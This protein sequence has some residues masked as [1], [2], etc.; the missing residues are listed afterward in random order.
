MA[1]FDGAMEG[2]FD[3]PQIITNT[4]RNISI[5]KS[6]KIPKNL[7]RNLFYEIQPVGAIKPHENY[8][9]KGDGYTTCVHIYSPPE[10]ITRHWMYSLYKLNHSIISID[11]RPMKTTTV[12]DA[13]NS[14]VKEQISRLDDAEKYRDIMRAKDANSSLAKM[15]LLASQISEMGNVVFAVDIRVF[16]SGRTFFEME[17]NVKEVEQLLN[18]AGFS[19]FSRNINEQPAEYKSLFVPASSTKATLNARKGIPVPANLLAHGLPFYYVGCQDPQGF[20][21]GD[22][23]MTHGQGYAFFN[24]FHLDAL[25]N[26]YDGIMFGLKGTGKS[27][28]LKIMIEFAYAT[29]NRVRVIDVVGDFAELVKNLGGTVIKFDGEGKFNVLNPIEIM[30]MDESDTQNYLKHISKL[31]LMYRSMSPDCDEKEIKLFK[32][33]LKKLYVK[34]KIIPSESVTIYE[35]ITGLPATSYPLFSDLVVL[36]EDEIKAYNK[37]KTADAE[38]MVQRLSDIKLIISDLVKNYGSI[39][40]KHTSF[41]DIQNA[42]LISFDLSAISDIDPTVYDMVLENVIAMAYDSCMATGIK[43]KELYDQKKISKED[44]I[45]HLIFIDE[46]EKTIKADKPYVVDKI[47]EYLQQNRKFFIGFWLCAHNIAYMCRSGND[48]SSKMMKQLFELCQYKIIFRQDSS[49]TPEIQEAFQNILTPQ[50]INCI[51]YL[52]QREMLLCLDPTQTI[53]V[54]CRKVPES[55]LAYYGGGA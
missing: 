55:K 26:C 1:S 53:R 46:C 13:I 12:R 49:A 5:F 48:A 9:T 30:K 7:D 4:V 54:M 15:D 44:V 19:N 25:R 14:A 52:Q 35:N 33:L 22:T 3:L 50:E 10:E 34:F 31:G 21:L 42:E 32:T 29:G 24:P 23:F 18:E 41:A 17:K 27:T 36:I 2:L 28:L 47:L 40:N 11:C 45:H 43:M 51:P 38:L 20:Y 8:L 6:N 16:V 39:F 37:M